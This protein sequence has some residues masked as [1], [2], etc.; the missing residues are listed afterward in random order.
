MSAVREADFEQH[1]Q[2]E[3]DMIKQCFAFD[4]VNYARYLS[5]QHVYLM[6]LERKQCP[7]IDDLKKRGFGGSLSGVKFS[8]MHGD[9]ITEVFNGETKRSAGPHR[10]GYS[11]NVTALNTWVLTSHLHAQVQNKLRE[12]IKMS[13][14]T[15]H[16]EIT[17]GAKRL[18]VSHVNDL[19][20]K[21]HFYNTN[22]F[23][24]GPARNITTGA[25]IESKV[26]E[27][28]LESPKIGDKKY[29]E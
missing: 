11:T 21:L 1:L 29:K 10:S 3:R 27:G 4:H 7:A 26:I 17:P 6:D 28:L 19:K 2:A 5:F 24:T 18:F 12:R 25:G 16:K 14:S 15:T 13:T 8:N 9:L 23:A 22:P 20:E